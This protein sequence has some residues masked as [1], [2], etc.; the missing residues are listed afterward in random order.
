MR[1]ITLAA[2]GLFSLSLLANPLEEPM[3]SSINENVVTEKYEKKNTIRAAALSALFPGAGQYYVDKSYFMT[4]V[5]PIVEIALWGLYFDY[6]KKGDDETEKYEYY[7][8]KEIIEVSGYYFNEDTKTI[9]YSEVPIATTRYSRGLFNDAKGNLET[10]HGEIIPF[11]LDE[12]N[13]QHFYEDIG[14][15]NKY[16]FGWHDWY[17]N[18]YNG[19][20]FGWNIVESDDNPNLWIGNTDSEGNVD[21]PYSQMRAKYIDMRGKAEDYYSNG[22]LCKVGILLNHAISSLDAI[23]LT[24]KYNKSNAVSKLPKV[25]LQSAIYNS[26]LIP[27]LTV[28]KRF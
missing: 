27:M 6:Q 24:R 13:T 25:G 20:G 12:T 1:I 14:K 28:S 19:S 4:Y 11:S 5:Y 9:E 16:V 8:N 10:A 17:N 2:M 18:Y 3:Q 23:R 22:D 7:A 21:A 26:E 15:Y